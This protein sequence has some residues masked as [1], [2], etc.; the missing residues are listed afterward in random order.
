M[1]HQEAILKRIATKGI[2]AEDIKHP[3]LLTDDQI[4]GIDTTK[5]YEWVKTGVWKQKDFKKWLRVMCVID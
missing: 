2:K 1:T 4:A 5:I 3:N